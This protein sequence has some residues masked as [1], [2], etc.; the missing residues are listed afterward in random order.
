MIC[1]IEVSGEFFE[2]GVAKSSAEVVPDFKVSL[3]QVLIDPQAIRVLRDRLLEWHTNPASFEVGLGTSKEGDQS[4]S[5]SLAQDPQLLYE[6]HRPAC[7]VTYG[8]PSSMHGRWSFVVDQSCV[9]SCADELRKVLAA[10]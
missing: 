2:R 10:D 9:R 3:S 1:S 8:S 5:L 7:I 4:L 6:I